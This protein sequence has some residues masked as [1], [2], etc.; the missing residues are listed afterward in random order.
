MNVKLIVGWEL[1]GETEVIGENLPQCQCVHQ[2]PYDLTW[3][4]N[5]AI[6]MGIPHATPDLWHVRC[7]S[8]ML[9]NLFYAT[10]LK[11]ILQRFKLI[12]CH[13]I[14]LYVHKIVCKPHISRLYVDLG[15]HSENY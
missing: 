11:L 14:H 7:T 13:Y 3:D 9:I 2:V 12:G 6:I 8:V 10:L 5:V 4:R 1:S 15:Y